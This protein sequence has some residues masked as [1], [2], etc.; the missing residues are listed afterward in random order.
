MRAL[1]AIGTLHDLEVERGGKTT[2]LK[3][4]GCWLAWDRGAKAFHIV[5]AKRR[6]SG[7]AGL[8][9]SILAAHRKFHDSDP[10][11]AMVAEVPVAKGKVTEIGLLRALVY[12]VPRQVKSPE[13]NPYVWHHAFGDTGHKGG[14]NYPDR[15]KPMLV[16]DAAGNYFIRRRPG[17]IFTV[18]QWLRG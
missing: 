13:K 17:N 15:V 3:P 14:K 10:L 2:H 11:G 16:R 6:Q 8:P 9:A 12:R 18:D 5:K 7:L 1:L 4:R